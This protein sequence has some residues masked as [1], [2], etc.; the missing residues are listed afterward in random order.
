M[1][2]EYL[3]VSSSEFLVLSFKFLVLRGKGRGRSQSLIL[4]LNS[5]TLKCVPKLHFGGTFRNGNGG[6]AGPGGEKG[7]D[8]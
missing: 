6:Q 4:S 5:K 3:L 2:T 7:N 8:R 1:D